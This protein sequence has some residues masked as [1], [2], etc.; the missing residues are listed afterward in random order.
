MYQLHIPCI[1]DNELSRQKIVLLY[2]QDSD[3]RQVS[4]FLTGLYNKIPI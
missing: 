1:I 2:L 3:D 4:K